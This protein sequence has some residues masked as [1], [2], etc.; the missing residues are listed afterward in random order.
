MA[1][2]NLMMPENEPIDDVTL[3][4]DDT[5]EDLLRGGM[6]LLQKKKGFRFGQDSVILAAYAA[7]FAAAD[8]H[9]ASRRSAASPVPRI[10]DLGAGCGAVSLLLAAR[11][12]AAQVAGL[13][14]DAASCDTFRRNIALNQLTGRFQAVQGDIRRLAAGEPVSDVLS[15]HAFDLA[16]C[17]PPYYLPGANSRFGRSATEETAVTLNE[18]MQA[19]ARLLRIGG[20][21]VMIHQTQRLPDVLF[22]ARQNRLEPKTLRLVQALPDRAPATFLFSAVN[23]GRPGGFVTEKPLVIFSRPGLWS[24]ETAAW[25]GWENPMAQEDLYRGLRCAATASLSGTNQGGAANAEP[26]AEIGS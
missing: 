15:T 10:V 11:L 4:P 25:Y 1:V 20:R 8:T 13:E 21:L 22:A 18:I 3:E 5:V 17:N 9:S 19:S 26:G 7:A 2:R 23:R 24:P 6:R 16:V 14:L 12:P